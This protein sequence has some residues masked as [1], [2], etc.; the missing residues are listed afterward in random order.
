MIMVK[1][2]QIKKATNIITD[3]MLPV[4][5]QT[6]LSL[7]YKFPIGTRITVNND[8][9]DRYVYYLKENA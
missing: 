5:E 6:M 3:C 7:L 9:G 2:I 4:C 1:E 8:N